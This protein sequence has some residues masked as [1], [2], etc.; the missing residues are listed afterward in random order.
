MKNLKRFIFIIVLMLFVPIVIIKAEDKKVKVYMFEAGGC[1]YCE[2]QEKYLKGLDSYDK[3]FEL[4]KKEL[5]VDHVDWEAGKDFELGMKVANEF[6]EA[7]FENASYQGTPFVVISNI[8]AEASYN[9]SLEDIIKS[10]YEQGDKDVVG[11]YEEG[12]TDCLD[13]LKKANAKKNK[14]INSNLKINIDYSV[15]VMIVGFIIVII[16]YLIKSNKDKKELIKIIEEYGKKNIKV[17]NKV[18]KEKSNKKIK[19]NKT[20]KK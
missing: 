7:G 5:Y 11:C 20:S 10:A 3:E 14:K 16:M 8:Y 9:D 2:E 13:D 18:S 1:P 6:N 17:D 15:V 19:E 12:K 4:I